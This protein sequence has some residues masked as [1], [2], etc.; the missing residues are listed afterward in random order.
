M[1]SLQ[2]FFQDCTSLAAGIYSYSLSLFQCLEQLFA[3]WMIKICLTLVEQIWGQKCPE[4]HRLFI[5]LLLKSYN[6]YRIQQL[7]G[8]QAFGT[9]NGGNNL[10]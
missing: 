1:C 3:E 4:I 8:S 10:E 9:N 6:H 5:A 7:K 2:F